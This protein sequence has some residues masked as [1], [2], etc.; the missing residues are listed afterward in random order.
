MPVSITRN[1]KIPNLLPDSIT[2]D[3][4]V[5]GIGGRTLSGACITFKTVR[6]GTTEPTG[7]EIVTFHTLGKS[8]FGRPDAKR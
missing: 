2:I 3:K 7:L 1:L 4:E 6:G 8:S 5:W